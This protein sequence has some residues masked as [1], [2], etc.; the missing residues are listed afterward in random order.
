VIVAVVALG[1]LVIVAGCSSNADSQAKQACQHVERSLR[2][3]AQAASNPNP[4]AADQ[5]RVAALVELRTALP[6]A[7]VAAAG[8]GQW[9]ALRTTLSESPNVDEGRLVPALTQQCQ[10]ALAPPSARTY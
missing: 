9:E 10:I 7:S 4:A 8:S 2:L 6:L 3:Y 1:F 5:E